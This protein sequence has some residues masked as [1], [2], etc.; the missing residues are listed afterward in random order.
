MF[1]FLKNITGKSLG[2][3]KTDPNPCENLEPEPEQI[4]S[5]GSI[6]LANQQYNGFSFYGGGVSSMN[7]N[8]WAE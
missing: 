5:F 6:T 2:S 4:G 8:D 1:Q 3:E 7:V